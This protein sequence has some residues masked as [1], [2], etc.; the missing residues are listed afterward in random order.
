[1][2]KQILVRRWA[3]DRGV[4]YPCASRGRRLG[5]RMGACWQM[6]AICH[7]ERREREVSWRRRSARNGCVPDL[8]LYRGTTF[9]ASSWREH[10]LFHPTTDT[11]TVKTARPEAVRRGKT[12]CCRGRHKPANR[13]SAWTA[14]RG[15]SRSQF[16]ALAAPGPLAWDPAKFSHML[17]L[18]G[19]YADASWL[20]IDRFFDRLAVAQLLL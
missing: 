2:R 19:A 1:M 3:A 18:A 5:K 6:L 8:R 10:A 9:Q 11:K 7:E 15:A 4:I 12:C 20:H 14:T 13:H 17:I 16:R